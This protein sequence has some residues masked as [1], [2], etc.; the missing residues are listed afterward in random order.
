MFGE[1]KRA[2]RRI[3]VGDVA[4]AQIAF[5]AQKFAG[6]VTPGFEECRE[7]GRATDQGT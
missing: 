4:D 5:I 6:I 1:A 2:A 3:G 7:R